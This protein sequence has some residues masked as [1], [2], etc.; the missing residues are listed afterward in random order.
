MRWIVLIFIAV[1]LA[2]MLLLFEVADRIGGLWTLSMVVMTAII[3]VQILRWQGLATL[4][5]AN[6]RL[7]TGQL[8]AQEIF[9]GMLL[10]AAGALLLT[11]GFITDTIGFV[12]LT[13]PIRRKIAGRIV[14]SHSLRGQYGSVF[15]SSNSAFRQPGNEVY[16][17]ELDEERRILDDENKGS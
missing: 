14:R 5:R 3:G 13:G 16:E 2:E 8:P 9:E 6:Q 10:A 1:P 15:F 7:Q 17:G 12:L 4:F 11:P